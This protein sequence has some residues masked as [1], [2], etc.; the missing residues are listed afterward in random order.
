M[1]STGIPNTYTGGTADGPG[2][3]AAAAAAATEVESDATMAATASQSPRRIPELGGGTAFDAHNDWFWALLQANGQHGVLQE[4]RRK[5]PLHLD[6]SPTS[7]RAAAR[8]ARPGI[9]ISVLH[10]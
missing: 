10:Q 4:H 6:S 3:V 8:G 9:F 2:P 5:G 1:K 7:Q